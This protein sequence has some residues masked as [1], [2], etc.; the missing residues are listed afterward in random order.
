MAGR[1]ME[2]MSIGLRES[3][4]FTYISHRVNQIRYLGEKLAAA[5]VPMVQPYGGHAIF[6]D[7]RAFLDHLDQEN[8]FPAQALASCPLRILRCP[9]HGARYYLCRS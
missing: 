7:A 8:D 3:V 5:K 1:D 2:A 9:D 4:D 6:V